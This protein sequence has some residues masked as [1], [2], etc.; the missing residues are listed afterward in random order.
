MPNCADLKDN[1]QFAIYPCFRVDVDP[2]KKTVPVLS[3]PPH[4]ER[5]HHKSHRQLI[6]TY[7]KRSLASSQENPQNH[8]QNLQSHHEGIEKT[9]KVPSPKGKEENLNG[10]AR[11]ISFLQRA[12]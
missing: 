7:T 1:S 6:A 4:E 9:I 10:L 3:L 8:H 12:W 11:Q 2:P 5:E